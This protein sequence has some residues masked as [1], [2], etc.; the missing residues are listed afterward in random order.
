MNAL[1]RLLKQFEYALTNIIRGQIVLLGC[2][3]IGYW[4][5]RFL[6]NDTN[7]YALNAS[8]LTII[9]SFAL[10]IFSIFFF[11]YPAMESS[12]F[13]RD[14]EA[15]L[16]KTAYRESRYQMAY[17]DFCKRQLK[18]RLWGYN[19]AAALS[20]I[21]IHFNYA[22][23][24]NIA[25]HTSL[26]KTPI[27][28]SKWNMTTLFAYELLGDRWRLGT[29]LSTVLFSMIFTTLVFGVQKPNR[30]IPQHFTDVGNHE[31]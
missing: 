2:N 4:L 28:I 30:L 29:P 6:L 11:V 15:Y 8:R 19:V 3:F 5:Y 31:L 22:L 18:Y 12:F 17:S 23:A 1:T 16:L 21:P 27:D 13:N 20:Q 26:Y 7:K 9:F 14:S 10:F 24:E 25:I